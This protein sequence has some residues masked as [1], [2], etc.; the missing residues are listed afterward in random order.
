MTLPA[1]IKTD[2]ILRT[3]LLQR[4]L[5]LF[6]SSTNNEGPIKVNDIAAA[7]VATHPSRPPLDN[8]TTLR[9]N[10]AV[11]PLSPPTSHIARLLRSI[12][13]THIAVT[14][15]PRTHRKRH[16]KASP[17]PTLTTPMRQSY[18]AFKSHIPSLELRNSTPHPQPIFTVTLT[19]AQTPSSPRLTIV[20][21]ARY[22]PLAHTFH[23]SWR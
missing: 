14:Y 15:V 18:T 19:L 13:S 2:E 23:F 6:I 1:N 22:F 10:A 16:Q 3:A 4:C 5:R 8:H 12:D 21:S 11:V 9:N 17:I 7:A 20:S